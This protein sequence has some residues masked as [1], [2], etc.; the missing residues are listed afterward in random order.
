[1]LLLV[2]NRAGYL[3]LCELLTKAW[4]HPTYHN[5]AVVQWSCLVEH[6]QGLIALSGAQ[7][8]S[9]GQALIQEN[10]IQAKEFAQT[11]SLVFPERFYV[12]LQRGGHEDDERYIA[13]ALR[14][15]HQL[16]LPVVATHPVQFLKPEDYDAHE[17]RVCIAEGDILGNPRRVRRFTTQQFFKTQA[18]M[19]AL[20]AD[21][22]SSLAN[23]VEI[24]KRCNL[25]L[26][27]GKNYLPDF[28][29]SP[30]LSLNEY[31]VQVTQQGLQDRL[32]R[33]TSAEQVAASA[34]IADYQTRLDFEM[35]TI[36][37]MG[38]AGYFLIVADFIAWAKSH[39]CP[40]GPGRGSGA[41]SLVA[42][43]LGITDLDPL[44]YQ[45]LFE[46]FLNPQRV[47]MPDFDIDFCQQGRDRVIDYVK[48]KYGADAVSQ[49]ATFGTMAA[50]AVIRDVG[51]VLDLS[52][53]F[54]DGIAKLIP[55]KPGTS[56]TLAAVPTQ[57]LADDKTLYAFEQEPQLA[58]RYANEEDVR[59]L[60]DLARRL[61]G[62]PRNVGMHAGGV[63]I[64]PGK[65]VNFCPLYQQPGSTAQVS[66]LD[67]DDVEA[68]GLVKFDFLGLATLTI[69]EKAR[70][71]IIQRHPDQKELR[72]ETIPLDDPGVYALFAQGRTEAVF[73]FESEGMQAMMREL[74]PTRIEDLIAMNALYRPGPMDLIPS[75]I[76]RKAGQEP[77]VYP[78]PRVEPILRETYGIMVY[79][80]QVM[81]MAQ[82][83][84]GYSLGDADLLRRAMGKKKPEEMAQH[85]SRFREGAAQQGLSA[86]KS[87]E[88]F[89]L[90]EKFAGYGF[91]KSH[92]AAYALLAYYTAWFKVHYTVEFFCANM[93]VE[94]GDTDKLKILWQDAKLAGIQFE[95]PHVN[96]SN[97]LFD[98]IDDHTIGYGLGALKGTGEQAVLNLVTE[99]EHKG[100][101][102][103]LFDFCER[104]DRS[105]VNKRAVD[106]LI[107]A[108]ALDDLGAHRAQLLAN[109]DRAF[110]FGQAQAAHADQVGLFDQSD[111]NQG[112]LTELELL[113]A[114]PWG[115][116]EQLEHE[117]LS[118]G[119]CLSG[120]LFDEAAPEI[121]QFVPH[122]LRALTAGKDVRAAGVVMQLRVVNGQRGRL[123][124]FKLDDSTAQVDIRMDENLWQAHRDAIKDDQLLVV[125]GKLSQD[126]FSG[127]LQ[128]HADQVWDLPSARCRFGRY[129]QMHCAHP[130]SSK[131]A[132]R[133]SSELTRLFKSFP[134]RS[135]IRP[136]GRLDLGLPIR[137]QLHIAQP[138]DLP[139]VKA[140]QA[141]IQLGSQ[142]HIFP[143]REAFHAWQ[144]AWDDILMED[145]KVP[146]ELVSE[147]EKQILIV[148]K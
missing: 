135:V 56:V 76:A 130:L 7:W 105:R 144:N 99:R 93:S 23:T 13:A 116:Q 48:A 33:Q 74:K 142:L 140:L 26:T 43:A 64:A 96:R 70:Q 80:E 75:Y 21:I 16:H 88:V 145:G 90:M 139:G 10:E 111:N 2:Q 127:R 138:A 108:G 61:E 78:D 92:S 71:L 41:G 100:P 102:I 112:P 27:L 69:L 133:L 36:T 123:I 89:D 31:F 3:N 124:L 42:Y 86:Q 22:P 125:Q 82:V 131:Q 4:A 117:K 6:A 114:R 34:S 101:F 19:E 5:Q 81:Q 17:A 37:Q 51:R 65:L 15:A 77:V 120:H 14:L 9:L 54:C 68:I 46:R 91:N 40:V 44:R 113:P 12:E 18:Q 122:R 50:R 24:A 83:L 49:I 85:R 59:L 62:L 79:Q 45:L 128:L 8:G 72:L 121:A 104:I 67:K 11:L 47:S 53:T 106:S 146:K 29:V 129:V 148:Y 103:H 58:Q 87:D 97:Y 38:F 109:L 94:L 147:P 32:S 20:F 1:L 95:S 30:G 143:S 39:D 66:Q 35:Q 132:S 57:K 137:W 141:Q 107:K 60:I 28:S 63:L 134:P 110:E 115:L 55:N 126:R 84:G 52:Y 119:F 136:E 25:E 73:Q 118:L 98:P